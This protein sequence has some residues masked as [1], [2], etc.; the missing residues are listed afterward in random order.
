MARTEKIYIYGA[1]GHGL[2]CADVAMSLDYKE[3]IFL[4]DFKGKKFE[5]SL[6]KYD[7]FIAI[8]NNEIRKKLFNQISDSGFKIVNLIHK[9]AIISQSVDIAEDAGILIMPYVVVN[10]RAKIEKGV[11]LNTSSVIEHECI[12]GE[13]S[14]ISVGAKCAGN[15]KI[16]KNCFLGI[17]SCVL[18]NL[19]LADDSIL[20]GGATLV[21]SQSE[22]G[23]FVGVPAKRM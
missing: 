18:P 19:S 3:C 23:V 21:K 22:K 12:V 13:F 2:V 11:I 10:A 20:G 8:G 16:G 9:S 5:I 14:H 17:N 1:S 4:D 6:P 15:V 7:V